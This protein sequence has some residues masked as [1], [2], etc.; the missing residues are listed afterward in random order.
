MLVCKKKLMFNHRLRILSLFTGLVIVLLIPQIVFAQEALVNQG[1]NISVVG[2]GNQSG[3]VGIAVVGNYYNLNDGTNDASIEL[4]GGHMLVTGDWTNDANN[5]VFTYFSGSKMD[6]YVTLANP[7]TPQIITGIRP[8]F[9]ENLVVSRSRKTLMIDSCSVDGA[10]FVDAPFVLNANTF[11]IKNPSPAG[12]NYQS[13]F[14]KSETMPGSYSTLRWNIGS[15][16]GGYNIPFGSDKGTGN[17]D[18]NLYMDIA[19]PMNPNDY[20]DFATYPTDY[21]NY[22]LPIGAD[23]LETEA[24]KVVDRFWIIKTS[25]VNTRPD[26]SLVFT[27]TSDDVNPVYNSLNLQ[28][29]KAARNNT[30]LGKWLDMEPKGN[31]VGNQVFVNNISGNDL[32]ESWILLNLPGPLADVFM[33][34][35]FSPNGDGINDVFL[36]VFHVDFEVIN[37]TFIIFNRWGKEVFKT[38]NVNEGWDGKPIDSDEVVIG[39][40]SWVIIVQGKSKYDTNAEGESK[41][42][43][44]KVTVFK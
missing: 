36:P 3:N 8:T 32:Y 38:N 44:G 30:L 28:Q 26:A 33:P 39:V 13:G 24:K 29:L 43:M 31:A 17:N 14:I 16:T 4:A 34:D 18:L 25:D 6:G 22:P 41:R 10:L 12:I 35:A 19:T 21:Y 23:P 2:P 20:I 42:Y 5:T 40:Y 9:F 15:G 7:A 27:F 1:A 37:Y 11:T